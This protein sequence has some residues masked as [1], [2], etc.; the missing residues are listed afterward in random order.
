[1]RT[2]LVFIIMT[3]CSSIASAQDALT[4][5]NQEHATS[6]MIRQAMNTVGL[7]VHSSFE[8]SQQRMPQLLTKIDGLAMDDP[9]LLTAKIN[10]DR[11]KTILDSLDTSLCDNH[12]QR[13]NADGLWELSHSLIGRTVGDCLALAVEANGWYRGCLG[14]LRFYEPM[15]VE[16]KGRL[17]ALELFLE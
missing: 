17:D 5:L 1:M 4:K 9:R 6:D 14:N 16:L 3:F 8:S 10:W 12:S 13:L 11:A 15:T 7:R 2:A